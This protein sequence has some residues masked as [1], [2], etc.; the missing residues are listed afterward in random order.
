MNPMT[1]IVT[2]VYNGVA[3]IR[4][5]VDSV[6]LQSWANM[7]HV[8]VGRASN[9]GIVQL[10]QS[11][12]DQFAVHVSERHG[13]IYDALKQGVS[14]CTRNVIGFLHADDLPV[15]DMA[16]ARIAAAFA[17][18]CVTRFMATWSTCKRMTTT[19]VVRYWGSV[20][21]DR[22]RLARDRCRHALRFTCAEACTNGC[23]VSTLASESPGTLTRCC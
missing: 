21:F 4:N 16:L 13:G 1:S 3:T 7:E 15:D 10:L 20:S 9:D 22:S 5:A 12:R 14:P 18:T 8:A 2:A 17:A 6:C 23:V 19:E 11:I